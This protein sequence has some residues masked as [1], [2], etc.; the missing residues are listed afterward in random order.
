[1][2]NPYADRFRLIEKEW[3]RVS[4]LLDISETRAALTLGTL[5]LAAKGVPM[6]VA[7]LV[8]LDLAGIAVEVRP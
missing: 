3:A 1:M 4:T 7:E 2:S 8:A 5:P 6:A